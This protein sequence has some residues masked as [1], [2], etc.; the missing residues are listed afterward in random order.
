MMVALMG[1]FA[2][3]CFRQLDAVAFDTVHRADMPSAP[4]TSICSLIESIP[5]IS[6]LRYLRCNG[7]VDASGRVTA[8]ATCGLFLIQ[9][10]DL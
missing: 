5:F 9:I 2:A 8:K 4:M 1:A 10:G 3:I 6:T 7:D